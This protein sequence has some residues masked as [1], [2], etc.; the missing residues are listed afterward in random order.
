[1][2]PEPEITINGVKLTPAHAMTLRVALCNFLM[3]L[4]DG[5]YMA[6]LGKIGP[7]YRD[8]AGEIVRLMFPEQ[9]P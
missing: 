2:N 3:E 5:T 9:K 4:G 7:L 8:R 6:E 1:M